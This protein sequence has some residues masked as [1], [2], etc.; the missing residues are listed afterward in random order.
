MTRPLTAAEI[1][2]LVLAVNGGEM[3]RDEAEREAERIAALSVKDQDAWRKRIAP[4]IRAH[5]D[6]LFGKE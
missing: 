6:R 4:I 3:G 2:L 1:L 5:R